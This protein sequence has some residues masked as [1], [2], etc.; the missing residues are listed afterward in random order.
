MEASTSD[1]ASI[2]EALLFSD[3]LKDLKNLRSQL[4][5]AADYFELFYRNN[6]QKPG[7]ING[8]K[9]YTVE[10]LVSTVDHLGFVSY[11]VNNLLTEKVDEVFEAEFMVSSV[12]QRIRTCQDVLDHEGRS[13]Q[14][15]VIR[16]PK[17]HK[18][19][20]VPGTNLLDSGVHPIKTF[21]RATHSAT[22]DQLNKMNSA[23]SPPIKRPPTIRKINTP[24][25]SNS[26]NSPRSRSVSP[27]KKCR[28]PSPSPQMMNSS[29]KEK[30]SMSPLPTSRLLS[31][32]ASLV[33]R[34]A[35]PNKNLARRHS[36]ESQRS[37]HLHSERTYQKE[38]ERNSNKSKSLLKSLLSRR[39]SKNPDESLY[40]YL[41]EY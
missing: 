16:A 8:L 40:S 14:S 2:Q 26:N 10:A 4:Y 23:I 25:P 31:R 3:S 1:E 33:S 35:S 22:N 17:F 29:S 32:A 39:R 36:M 13:Q 18:H 20:I 34:P 12:E 24:S 38:M 6:S 9:D 19:Y 30:R 11:K 37:V 41:D 15:L 5:S 27:S 21:Q 7:M 28:S